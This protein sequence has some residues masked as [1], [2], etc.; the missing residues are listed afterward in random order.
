MS[1]APGTP[2]A[3]PEGGP[4]PE[5]KGR[6]IRTVVALIAAMATVLLGIGLYLSWRMGRDIA[7]SSSVLPALP[8]LLAFGCGSYGCRFMRWHLLVR[9]LAP[10][11]PVTSSLRIY[12]AGFAMGLTPGRVGEFLKFS[13]LRDATGI[14]ELESF[15]IFPL[16]R[17]TE[18]AAFLGLA[19]VG[20][21]FGHLQLHRIGLGSLITIAVL[22]GLAGL[23]LLLRLLHRRRHGSV[24][25][26]ATTRLDG[27]LRGLLTVAGLRALLP[28]LCCAALARCFDAALFYSAARAVGL[29]LSLPGA[30]MAWGLAG[31]VGGLS[32]LPAGVGAVE[33]SLVTT[34]IG[35]GGDSAAALAAALL[36]RIMTL[37]LW[38]PPGL[39]LAF[40]SVRDSRKLP[41]PVT[42]ES[43]ILA[44]DD[45]TNPFVAATGARRPLESR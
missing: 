15:S 25:T 31:L 33:A 38:I 30:A 7:W 29:T 19:I 27:A 13:L 9:R 24:A 12:M 11:L 23:G 4:A 16:E 45:D 6:S 28:A 14:A 1:L 26:R 44:V 21:L 34:V 43:P 5:L 35:L 10:H 37:W 2:P 39:W 18:A 36:A 22:P 41:A 20:A 32:L 8:L 17:A 40:R 42:A 3:V